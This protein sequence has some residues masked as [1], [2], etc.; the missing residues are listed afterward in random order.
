MEQY[1]ELEYS[2]SDER[3]WPDQNMA[4]SEDYLLRVVWIV[5]YAQLRTISL[6]HNRLDFHTGV[7]GFQVNKGKKKG[8]LVR[9]FG[10]L[11]SGI[12]YNTDCDTDCNTDT[13][14]RTTIYCDAFCQLVAFA[15]R[16][17][18]NVWHSNIN[19]GQ[20]MVE[21]VNNIT[22]QTNT[23]SHLFETIIIGL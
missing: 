6:L 22:G 14:T 12:W 7:K 2:L 23:F 16:T 17:A 13:A 4:W 21:R 9:Q 19:E 8:F 11:S 18:K 5:I 15:I 1:I 20:L 10:L 3:I